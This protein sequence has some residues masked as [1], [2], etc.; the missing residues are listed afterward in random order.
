MRVSL[1]EGLSNSRAKT[2]Y[3]HLTEAFLLFTQPAGQRVRSAFRHDHDLEVCDLRLDVE[4]HRIGEAI[5]LVRS[6]G[7]NKRMTAM[8]LPD[9][10]PACAVFRFQEEAP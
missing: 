6:F 9:S 10:E 4:S 5:V 7:R 1:R 3:D 8:I 2:W